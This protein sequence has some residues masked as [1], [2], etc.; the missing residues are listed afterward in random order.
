MC[1]IFGALGVNRHFDRPDWEKFVALTDLVSYRGPDASGYLAVDTQAKTLHQPDKFDIFLGHRRLSIIDLSASGNQPLSDGSGLWIVFNGEIFNYLELKKDLQEKGYEF[2]TKT[3]TEVI[4][5]IYRE[6]GP[7]GFAHLNGMWA[8]ALLDLPGHVLCLSRDRFSIK[9]LFYTRTPDGI[10]FASEIKQLLPLLPQTEINRDTMFSYL[11]QGCLDHNDQTFYQN[12][13]KV[14]PKHSLIIRLGG[15]E[16]A[17]SKYWDFHLAPTPKGVEAVERFRELFVD[18]VKIR[19][20]SDVKIGALLSG[21]LDSSAI[22]MIAHELTRGNFDTY[23]IIS[24]SEKYSEEKFVDI[25]SGRKGIRNSK[26]PYRQAEALDS[27]PQVVFHQEEPFGGFSIVAQYKILEKIRKETDIIVVLSGQ[28]GDEILMGYL[29]YFFFNL[30]ELLRR[31]DF[32]AAARQVFFALMHR[33]VLSQFRMSEAKRYIPRGVPFWNRMNPAP[34]LRLKGDLEPIW[35]FSGITQRQILDI[36]KYS[37]PAL[38]HYEDR[39]SMAHSLE[40]RLPFLDHRLVN[41]TLSLPV[42]MKINHGWTKYVLRKSISELPELIKW[43]RDKQGFVTPEENWIRNDFRGAIRESFRKSL[44]EELGII[45]ARSFLA[46]YDEFLGG[47]R[48]ILYSDISRV[49]LAELWARKFLK[50]KYILN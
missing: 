37:V 44:L 36:D 2:K 15:G 12:V 50:Q 24:D 38:T 47:K 14:K 5:K 10:F 6:Y 22:V 21:G 39:N 43:R 28:G 30:K 45:D 16:I 33:T 49:F 41:Y 9:P 7:D 17:E 31:G 23:S 20:R 19:L 3:D 40:T 13:Y 48:T 34:Y 1:G 4:L 27:L 25:L 26:L 32:P 8:F 35:E 29:K 46:F 11:A 42:E 18:S